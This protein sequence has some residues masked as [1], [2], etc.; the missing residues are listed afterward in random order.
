MKQGI[1]VKNRQDGRQGVTIDELPRMSV[2]GPGEQ[3][4]VYEGSTYGDGTMEANLEVIG[5]ENVRADFKKCGAGDEA[6]CCMFLVGGPSGAECAR[7]GTLR[8]TLIFRDGMTAQRHP[9][10]SFPECQKAE[11]AP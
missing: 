1:V 2:C 8:N 3:L 5:P 11:A 9:I 4:V 6:E 7:F 10:E